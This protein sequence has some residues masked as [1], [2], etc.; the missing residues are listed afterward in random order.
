MKPLDHEKSATT[1]RHEDFFHQFSRSQSSQSSSRDLS[2][3]NES[4]KL[5]QVS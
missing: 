4:D 2:N 3:R 1:I 5:I